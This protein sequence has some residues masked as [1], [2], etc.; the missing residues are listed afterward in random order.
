MPNKFFPRVQTR[1]NAL[2]DLQLRL[3]I[4]FLSRTPVA[5]NN[6]LVQNHRKYG[7]QYFS[8]SFSS[9]IGPWVSVGL[10]NHCFPVSS[11]KGFHPEQV[12]SC[13]ILAVLK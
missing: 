11:L 8:M 6:C 1:L 10:E 7:K 5:V 2:R 13:R 4:F 9:S 12:H 3:F